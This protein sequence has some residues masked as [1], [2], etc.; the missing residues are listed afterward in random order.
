MNYW[1]TIAAV[2]VAFILGMAAGFDAGR[3]LQDQK[4]EQ[5]KKA[6]EK[7]EYVAQWAIK[8]KYERNLYMSPEMCFELVY[9]K[10]IE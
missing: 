10:L 4:L 1:Q 5:G 7:V 3:F 6:R 9:Q 8:C 2:V